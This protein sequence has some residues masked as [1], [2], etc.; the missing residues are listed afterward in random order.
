MW[1]YFVCLAVIVYTPVRGQRVGGGLRAAQ[2][3]FHSLIVAMLSFLVTRFAESVLSNGSF[4]K[5]FSDSLRHA[6]PDV[7][8]VFTVFFTANTAYYLVLLIK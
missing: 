6:V 1:C 5:Q 7:F 8:H 4:K 3:I 2:I